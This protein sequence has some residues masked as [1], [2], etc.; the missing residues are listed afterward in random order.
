MILFHLRK[1]LS[2]DQRIIKDLNVTTLST[3][4]KNTSRRVPPYIKQAN[5]AIMDNS[6]GFFK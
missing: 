6:R 2:E 4:I 1:N 3:S 5:I